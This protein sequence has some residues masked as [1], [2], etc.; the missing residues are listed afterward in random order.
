MTCIPFLHNNGSL[1]FCFTDMSSCEWLDFSQKFLKRNLKNT[2]TYFLLVHLGP[3]W[4]AIWFLLNFLPI[5]DWLLYQQCL[6]MLPCWQQICAFQLLLFWCKIA[7][8]LSDKLKVFHN[9]SAMAS[10]TVWH[11]SHEYL[12]EFLGCG[13]FCSENV[14]TFFPFTEVFCI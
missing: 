4:N 7:Q 6:I 2:A 9:S 14:L 12:Q 1:L 3:Y 5:S 10:L 13:L 11:F 8:F